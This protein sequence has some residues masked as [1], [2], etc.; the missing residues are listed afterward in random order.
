[1]HTA[2]GLDYETSKDTQPHPQP[3]SNLAALMHS[4]VKTDK[5]DAQT[6]RA[7]LGTIT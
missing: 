6:I 3:G 5:T 7:V 4:V 2:S 1:M